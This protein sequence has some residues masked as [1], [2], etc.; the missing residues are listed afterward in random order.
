M[1]MVWQSATGTLQT[2]R[3]D[4]SGISSAFNDPNT[5]IN[6]DGPTVLDAQWQAKLMATYMAR[7][8]VNLS[9]YYLQQSGAPLYR[10]LSIQ[11]AQGG[12]IPI[13]AD[14]KET[15]RED[16][17]TRLDL[18]AEKTFTFG[19]RNTRLSLMLD[20]FNTFNAAAITNRNEGTTSGGGFRRPLAVQPPRTAR[21]GARIMF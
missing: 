3:N 9:G 20:V 19:S 6:I 17:L 4:A 16:P 15:H 14:P 13:V 7:W 12:P 18:R 5:L 21:I 10:T 2:N 8:G 1:S 11:L